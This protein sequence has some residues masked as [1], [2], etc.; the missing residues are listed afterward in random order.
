MLIKQTTYPSLRSTNSAL[1]QAVNNSKTSSH[2]VLSL[3][4]LESIV[5]FPCDSI[6]DELIFL[7]DYEAPKGREQRHLFL[8]HCQVF[9]R[10]AATNTILA[11]YV[12]FDTHHVVSVKCN[13]FPSVAG[14]RIL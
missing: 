2:C 11:H 4:W 12:V 1:S 8:F 6:L 10:D 3:N 9:T 14:S 5:T 13:H 7:V